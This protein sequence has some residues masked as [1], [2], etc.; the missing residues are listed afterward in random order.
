MTAKSDNIPLTGPSRK[1]KPAQAVSDGLLWIT[2]SWASY[3]LCPA[4]VFIGLLPFVRL[5]VGPDHFRLRLALVGISGA[6]YFGAVEY[7]FALYSPAAWVALAV[8]QG[9]TLLPV[10]LTLRWSD[11]R[12]IPMALALPAFWVAGEYLR[13]LGPF[14]FPNGALGPVLFRILPA[15]QIADLGGIFIVSF[16][17]AAVSGVLFDL[18]RDYSAA[19][20]ADWRAMS[21]KA[22]AVALLWLVILGYGYHRLAESPGAAQPG[23]AP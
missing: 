1:C 9:I 16:A 3:Y 21:R 13:T 10:A 18:W 19:P 2:I 7:W 22:S 5:A 8:L 11:R 14:G 12:N 6:V 4:L 20:R 23:P 15:I 17:A